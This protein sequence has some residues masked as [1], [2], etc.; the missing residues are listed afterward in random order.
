MEL[1]K[2]KDIQL[3]SAPEN[4]GGME[5][6]R[7]GSLCPLKLCP[8]QSIRTSKEAKARIWGAGSLVGIEERLGPKIEELLSLRTECPSHLLL[9]LC[10]LTL[11]A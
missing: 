9:F 8:G 11:S 3:T 10:Y 5:M 2:Q 1:E 7:S 4:W 6:R